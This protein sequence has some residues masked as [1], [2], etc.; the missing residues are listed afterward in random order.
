MNPYDVLYLRTTRHGTQVVT[1]HQS[2]I[3][4]EK[5]ETYLENWCLAHGS[6]LRGSADVVR[7]HLKVIQKLPVLVNPHGGLFFFPTLSRHHPECIWINVTQIRKL[8]DLGNKTLV[9][10]QDGELELDVGIRSIRM[11]M[12]RCDLL[13]NRLGRPLSSSIVR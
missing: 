6:S 1:E 10:F 11:Q 9:R 4:C 8:K 13:R 7:H 3:L 2:Y 5:A 12:K